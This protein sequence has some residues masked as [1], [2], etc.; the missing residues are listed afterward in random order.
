MASVLFSVSVPRKKSSF[1]SHCLH[2][3]E[4]KID[5]SN[6]H[7]KFTLAYGSKILQK[8]STAVFCLAPLPHHSSFCMLFSDFF[9]HTLNPQFS[10]CRGI[11]GVAHLTLKKM[12]KLN[13]FLARPV[14]YVKLPCRSLLKG[15]I[16]RTMPKK[17]LMTSFFPNSLN[18]KT[19]QSQKKWK[20]DLSK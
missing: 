12:G 3:S 7:W 19:S 17:N 2:W 5:I 11:H 9:V 10:P 16:G 13:A 6:V 18:R 8:S 15:A 4:A 20:I 14:E 1:P